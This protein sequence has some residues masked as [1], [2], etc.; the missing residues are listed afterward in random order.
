MCLVLGL[1]ATCVVSHTSRTLAVQIGG[2]LCAGVRMYVRMCMCL[3]ACKCVC[4]CCMLCMQCECACM[5]GCVHRCMCIHE[6]TKSNGC[7]LKCIQTVF[8]WSTLHSIRPEEVKC[9]CDN[10]YSVCAIA[11]CSSSDGHVSSELRNHVRTYIR[12]Y[13]N[14]D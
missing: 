12:M 11:V 6:C 1:G 4:V 9:S 13:Y 8:L 3:C 7:W 2:E 10:D 14:I 5:G